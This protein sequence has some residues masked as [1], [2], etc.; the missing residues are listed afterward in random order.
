MLSPS[1]CK[2]IQ[3]IGN[4]TTSEV[5]VNRFPVR[6]T[7]HLTMYSRELGEE[8]LQQA[9]QV[10]HGSR[11]KQGLQPGWRQLPKFQYVVAVVQKQHRAV[12]LVMPNEAPCMR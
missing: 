6:L 1:T 10:C 7:L 4:L 8:V 5:M 2:E 11:C 12:V 9:R 3:K